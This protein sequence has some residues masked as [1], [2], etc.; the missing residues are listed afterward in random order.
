MRYI[1]WDWDPD[2]DDNTYI[3]DF[4]YLLREGDEVRCEYDRF[5]M[6]LFSRG[7]W[8]HLLLDVGFQAFAI[9]FIHSTDEHG[10]GEVFMGIKSP[11]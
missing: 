11:Q 9:P 5:I 2:P 4:A 10:S 6:G 1:A 8:L 3:T 7:D